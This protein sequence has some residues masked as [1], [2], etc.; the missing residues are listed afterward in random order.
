M[1]SFANFLSKLASSMPSPASATEILDASAP[2]CSIA[3]LIVM[4]LP[5]LFANLLLFNFTYPLQKKLL[6]IIY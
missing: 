2:N 3:Y 4:K 6:G 5:V 1:A